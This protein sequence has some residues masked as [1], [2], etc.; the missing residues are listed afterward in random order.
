MTHPFISFVTLT[1]TFLLLTLHHFV[2]PHFMAIH[3][4]TNHHNV[5]KDLI[6]ALVAHIVG[7]YEPGALLIFVPGLAEI[8]D[9][10]DLLRSSKGIFIHATSSHHPNP[11][12]STLLKFTHPTLTLSLPHST[13]FPTLPT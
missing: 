4:M 12:P 7:S 5:N 9:L 13:P 1:L 11:T 2:I 10:C 3:F 6:V 8:R